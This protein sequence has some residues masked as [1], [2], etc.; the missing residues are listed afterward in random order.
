MHQPTPQPVSLCGFCSKKI[1][2]QHKFVSCSICKSKVHIKCNNIEW[3]TY[4]KMD[5]DKEIS[6]CN[7]CNR[8]NFPFHDVR[9]RDHEIFN[10][11]FLAS[12][13]IKLFFKGINDFNNQQN[14][15][16]SD[17]TN[18]DLDITPILD[19]KY[20]DIN[21]FKVHKVDNKFFSLIHLNIGSLRKHKDELETV[22][23]LLNFKFDVI[24]IS[25][26]KIKKNIA[27]DYDPNIK[28]YKKPYSTPTEGGKGGVVIYISDKHN[29]KPRKDLDKISYK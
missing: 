19:C 27:P 12:E 11:E 21:S 3:T 28:G 14:N 20:F 24:G 6:M 23:S 7:T 1:H 5:K 18:D 17:T 2:K 15:G 25:E 16:N 10:R 9:E 22:L 29:C 13:D 8:E 4:N 26:T